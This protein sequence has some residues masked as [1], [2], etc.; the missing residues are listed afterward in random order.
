MIK[1]WIVGTII[2][3]NASLA[4]SKDLSVVVVGLFS[5]QAV[6]EI[7]HKQQL[8]KVGKTSPE[9]V[10]LISA[11]SKK[12]VLEIDGIKR[13]YELGEHISSSYSSTTAQAEVNLWPTN[14][15]YLT[16][17]SVNG[18]TVDFLVDT[19]ATAIA[20]NAATAQRVGLDYLNAKKIGI[21]TA[22]GTEIGYEVSLDSVQVG[23]ITLNNVRAMVIDG[24]Q[25]ERALLGMTFLN[26][27]EMV[28]TGEKMNLKQKY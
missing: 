8:L 23:D 15:M 14:G 19:G 4:W 10:K 28:R 20:L 25:P 18:Y 24:E 27:L 13:T 11:N 1:L 17:G 6:V 5:D 7:N 12:A 21:K 16:A 3:L 22:S 9:G 26:Q 2:L